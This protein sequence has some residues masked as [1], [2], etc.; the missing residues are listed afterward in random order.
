MIDYAIAGSY[1]ISPRFSLVSEILE[2]VRSGASEGGTGIG[3][4]RAAETRLLASWG[5][6]LLYERSQETIAR[7]DLRQSGRDAGADRDLFQVLRASMQTVI[8][9]RARRRRP[10]AFTLV[11]GDCFAV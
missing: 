9:R 4:R 7:R 10:A 3:A 1:D 8:W 6:R 11:D 5:G 2:M